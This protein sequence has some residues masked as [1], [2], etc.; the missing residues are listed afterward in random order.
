MV[1][2]KKLLVYFFCPFLFIACKNGAGANAASV[3]SSYKNLR[4]VDFKKL[5][6]LLSK[7]DGQIHVVNFWATWCRPCVEE[8]PYFEKLNE[9]EAAKVTLV[10]LDLPK[11]KQTHLVPFLDKRQMLTPVV[12]LDD[13][14]TNAWIPQVDKSW[15]G[16]IPAT[17][18]YKDGERVFYEEPF[19]SYDDLLNAVEK[20]KD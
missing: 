16:A 11:L 18:V 9:E 5:Q 10:S 6:P 15:S 8:L 7:E 14:N 1:R 2:F 20:M 19:K 17:L 4:T 13:P 12:L 3:E